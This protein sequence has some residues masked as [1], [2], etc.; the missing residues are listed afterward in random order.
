MYFSKSD[1]ASLAAPFSFYFLDIL[2]VYILNFSSSFFFRTNGEL[3]VYVG[4]FIHSKMMKVL[5][6][7]Y[8]PKKSVV[9][10]EHRC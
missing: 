3:S 6:T 8:F 5:E 9:T 4:P 7:V 2:I 1:F 10:E